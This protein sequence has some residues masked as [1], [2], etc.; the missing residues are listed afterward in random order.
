MAG[1][2][3]A[4]VMG[5]ATTGHTAAAVPVTSIGPGAEQLTGLFENTDLFAAMARALG[6]VVPDHELA[7]F[8]PLALDWPGIRSASR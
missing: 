6:L 2:D 4:F 1:T 5:W 7:D 3:F 8:A